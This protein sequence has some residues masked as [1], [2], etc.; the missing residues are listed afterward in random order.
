M[1]AAD[2]SAIGRI[3]L[4]VLDEPHRDAGRRKRLL[5][6]GL[7]EI[8]ARIGEAA[9]PQQDDA[10]EVDG[11]YFHGGNERMNLFAV[12]RTNGYGQ[13]PAARAAGATALL[14]VTI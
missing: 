8:A 11:L 13:K 6:V 1:Q 14:Y 9:W 10:G 2:G 3:G 12:K 5:V 4:I 7:D